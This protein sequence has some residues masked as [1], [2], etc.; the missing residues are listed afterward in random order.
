MAQEKTR[1]D[2]VDLQCYSKYDRYEDAQY[3]QIPA[4]HYK[5][6]VQL[7]NTENSFRSASQLSGSERRDRSCA[8]CVGGHE[9]GVQLSNDI[10]ERYKRDER[11][12]TK[13]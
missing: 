5:E 10:A 13:A 9:T 12:R 3:G 1:D 4:D 6:T 7:R 2:G 11:H 8:S